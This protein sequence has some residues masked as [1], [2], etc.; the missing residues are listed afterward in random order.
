[1]A[2]FGREV[3]LT[4]TEEN[5][6]RTT[7]FMVTECDSEKEAD[8]KTRKWIGEYPELLKIKGNK[9]I[10]KNTLGK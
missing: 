5:A 8:E 7:R 10:I 4:A 6:F 9:R 3:M 1:M 2:K